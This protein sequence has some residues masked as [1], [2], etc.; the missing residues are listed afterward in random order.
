V[1]YALVGIFWSA[2][3]AHRS[4]DRGRLHSLDL[5]SQQTLQLLAYPRDHLDMVDGIYYEFIWFSSIKCVTSSLKGPRSLHKCSFGVTQQILC[6]VLINPVTS[7]RFA[8]LLF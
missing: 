8:C 2:R 4:L 7:L 1:F 3:V 6:I 5:L